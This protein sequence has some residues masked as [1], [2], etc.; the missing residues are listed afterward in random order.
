MGG[1][2]NT[3]GFFHGREP[4]LPRTV[5]WA[6]LVCAFLLPV[7]LAGG[8]NHSAAALFFAAAFISRYAGLVAE[9]W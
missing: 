1:S 5:K 2:F 7:L 8:L 4:S 3:R 6:F 9:R